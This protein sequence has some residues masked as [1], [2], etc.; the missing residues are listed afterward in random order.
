M[1]EI[2]EFRPEDRQG[3]LDLLRRGHD[4]DF[5]A[6]RFDWLHFQNPM[7]PS[8]IAICVDDREV[9]AFYAAIKKKVIIDG[10]A[11][12]GARDIDP[13]VSP[14]YRGRGI[15]SNLLQHALTNFTK[16]DFF[17]NFAN[18]QSTP[19][20][21]KNGWKLVGNLR[22]YVCQLGYERIPSRKFCLYLL[23]GSRIGSRD[24][25]IVRSIGFDEL[26]EFTDRSP[27][28]PSGR[29]WVERSL[30][31]LKWRYRDSPLHEY[32]CWARFSDGRI[33]GLCI[34]EFVASR[35]A[36]YIMDL[37]DYH[38]G[39]FR[40][41]PFLP[42]LAQRYRNAWTCIWQTTPVLA[43]RH[44]LTNPLHRKA[45]G[46]FLFRPSASRPVRAPSFDLNQWFICPGDS[47]SF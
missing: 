16:I 38:R 40:L 3:C 9:V 20:F 35:N 4:R 8:D 31:Y 41:S 23:T 37:V 47:E 11:H 44:F 43:R 29:I 42:F 46:N 45:G 24:A 10:V 12:L 7:A 14:D 13:V 19:G 6:E 22:D 17:F 26:E 32:D 30:P 28:P 34:T 5:S 1:L 33:A 21:L 25:E 2:R 27:V 36:L 39:D 15:F 18:S